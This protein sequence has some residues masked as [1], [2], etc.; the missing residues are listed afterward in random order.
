MNSSKHLFSYAAKYNKELKLEQ[1][2]FVF[3]I[4][5]PKKNKLF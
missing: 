1:G 4:T 3:Y 2:G 5:P